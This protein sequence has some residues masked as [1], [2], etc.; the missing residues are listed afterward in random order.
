[1]EICA[2]PKELVGGVNVPVQELPTPFV[3]VPIVP[4]VLVKNELNILTRSSLE[5]I[6]R[7]VVWPAVNVPDPERVMEM[8][9]IGVVESIVIAPV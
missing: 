6:V 4:A 9:G 1:M 2:V 5:V 3:R 8:L 7:V